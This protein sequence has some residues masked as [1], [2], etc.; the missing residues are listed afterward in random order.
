M[1]I[2]VSSCRDSILLHIFSPMRLKNCYNITYNRTEARRDK[3][4]TN[5]VVGDNGLR[6]VRQKLCSTLDEAIAFARDT[7]HLSTAASS[8]SL[9]STDDLTSTP[10]V[11]QQ[12]DKSIGLLG[13]GSNF[14][15]GLNIDNNQSSISSPSSTYCVVKP[16]RGVAS[17][18]VQFC[19]TLDEIKNAF[20]QIHQTPVFGCASGTRHES[21][22]SFEIPYISIFY[23]SNITNYLSYRFLAN[24]RICE[25][26]R[27]C[28]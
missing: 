4:L 15:T 3:Y 2:I 27:I 20:Q 17:D 7:L 24:S 22:V 19:Q 1:G 28:N 6:V 21:V 14:P 18:D 13:K 26:D 16:C 10:G 11:I 5:Q 23:D 8:A 9:D 12:A 25:R